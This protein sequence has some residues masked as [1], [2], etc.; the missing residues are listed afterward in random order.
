MHQ[1]YSGWV[2]RRN[3]KKKKIE[4]KSKHMGTFLKVRH[5][6]F[7]Y[8][9]IYAWCNSKM[10]LNCSEFKVIHSTQ[11]TI[12]TMLNKWYK[13]AFVHTRHIIITT[14]TRIFPNP[15]KNIP[16][17][18]HFGRKSGRENISWTSER[19]LILEAGNMTE[20]EH[21]LDSEKEHCDIQ[22]SLTLL[23]GQKLWDTNNSTNNLT[24]CY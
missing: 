13:T 14:I 8:L 5:S 6:L 2:W 23:D 10:T 1:R 17:S 16:S 11:Y 18:G 4:K 15:N 12:Y 3:R 7:I 24:Q 21:I 19:N 22:S 9:F 20:R